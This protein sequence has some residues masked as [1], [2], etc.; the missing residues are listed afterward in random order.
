M[1]HIVAE[2]LAR[3]LRVGYSIDEN[4]SVAYLVMAT[5]EKSLGRLSPE[6]AEISIRI[7]VLIGE[8]LIERGEFDEAISFSRRIVDGYK[9]LGLC[10][11]QM[12]SQYAFACLLQKRG[13]DREALKEL[14]AILILWLDGRAKSVAISIVLIALQK[15]YAKSAYWSEVVQMLSEMLETA[16][17]SPQW[18]A[19]PFPRMLYQAMNLAGLFSFLGERSFAESLFCIGLARLEDPSN[20]V[21]YRKAAVC[22]WYADHV[23]REGDVL[24][25]AIYLVTT[26]EILVGINRH[27]GHLASRARAE[28]K[29][30]LE[31]AKILGLNRSPKFARVLMR[32]RHMEDEVSIVRLQ[33]SR[34]GFDRD[35]AMTF[36][37]VSTK[38]FRY[39]TTCTESDF[40]GFDIEEFMRPS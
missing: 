11:I 29:Q 14:Y 35:D 30:A 27:S 40:L 18:D 5:C 39:G 31:K 1:Y 10:D 21:G 12:R 6:V 17:K 13:H 16:R 20:R 9:T 22:Y 3:I 25:S 7:A 15:S 32:I 24:K 8:A 34:L 23:R 36:H 38:S 19:D 2:D 28:L 37:T 26:L 33:R 4:L